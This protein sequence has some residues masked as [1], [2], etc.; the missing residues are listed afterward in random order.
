MG[1]VRELASL[2]HR[3]RDDDGNRRLV[4]RQAVDEGGVGAILQQAAHEIGQQ[5]LMA[6]HG[7]IDAA[8][9]VQ[10]V[11]ADDLLIERLAHAMQPL[12]FEAPVIARHHRDCGE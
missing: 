11:L 4:I 8:G 5:V 2:N 3:V 7:S 12:E 1:N 10:L 6:S 9:L